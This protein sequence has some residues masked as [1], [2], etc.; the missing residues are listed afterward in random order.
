MERERRLNLYLLV[1]L[2]LLALELGLLLALQLAPRP[3]AA[4]IP[5]WEAVDVTGG[6]LEVGE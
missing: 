3:D 2:G 1:A 6:A 4:G 5:G